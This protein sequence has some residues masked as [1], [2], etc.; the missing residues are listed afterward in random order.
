[1]INLVISPAYRSK[2]AQKVLQN[3]ATQVLQDQSL[4]G[5]PDLS[6][7]IAGNKKIRQLNLEFREIDAA[8]DVLSF[9]DGE[10]DPDTGKRYLGDIIISYPFARKQAQDESHSLD[11]ELQLLVV[12][13]M[14]HLLGYDHTTPAEKEKMWTAQSRILGRLGVKISI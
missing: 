14:L 7:V 12:H 1:M 10:V 2:I 8:T 9:R 13:G 6:I 4:R 11:E 5:D 3:A